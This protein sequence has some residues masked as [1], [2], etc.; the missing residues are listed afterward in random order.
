TATFEPSGFVSYDVAIAAGQ[1]ALAQRQ[2]T[3]AQLAEE[4]RN[5]RKARQ[6]ATMTRDPAVNIAVPASTAPVNATTPAN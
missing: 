3:V 5:E 4:T 1:A 2:K 6:A